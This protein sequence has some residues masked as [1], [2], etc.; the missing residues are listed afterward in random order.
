M[1]NKEF[2]NNIKEILE[3][4]ENSLPALNNRENILQSISKSVK[5]KKT[6]KVI[7]YTV[8][9]CIT[10]ILGLFIWRNK[11]ENTEIEPITENIQKEKPLKEEYKVEIEKKIETIPAVKKSPEI[12]VKKVL[13]EKKET[14][15]HIQ[16]IPEKQQEEKMQ[17][18][19]LI[20]PISL[21][22]LPI[23]T[24]PAEIKIVPEEK[25]KSK[26]Y[27]V[28]VTQEKPQ[29]NKRFAF[30]NYEDIENRTYGIRIPIKSFK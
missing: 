4:G 2:D 24:E 12:I 20:K 14:D 5:R 29:Q 25:E 8:A 26:T 11:V 28:I 22:V 10:I 23:N 3:C 1:D 7:Y 30:A 27:I 9:A 19:D 15:N 17:V 18:A 16:T 13:N 6:Y 21:T